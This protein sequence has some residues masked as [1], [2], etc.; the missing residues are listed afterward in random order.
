MKKEFEELRTAIGGL[1]EL[2]VMFYRDCLTYE[3]ADTAMKMTIGMLQCLL[4]GVNNEH[5]N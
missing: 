5:T 3:D 1:A 2:C 4:R